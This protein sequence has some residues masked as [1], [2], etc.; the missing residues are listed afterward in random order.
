MTCSFCQAEFDEA[1]SRSHC[2]GCARLG[3]AGCRSVRCPRCG[4]EMPEP[5]KLTKIFEAWRKRRVR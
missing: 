2:E 4:Y 1:L 5:L 3:G